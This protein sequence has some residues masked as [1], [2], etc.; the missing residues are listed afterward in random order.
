MTTVEV[1]DSG[2]VSVEI[3]P[4]PVIEVEVVSQPVIEVEVSPGG[5]VQQVVGV[6]PEYA[7][8][9]GVIESDPLVFKEFSYTD[10]DLTQIDVWDSAAKSTLLMQKVLTYSEG[11]L[12][13]LSATYS[14]I[15]LTNTY[16]FVDGDLRSINITSTQG[17]NPSPPSTS[18]TQSSVDMDLSSSRSLVMRLV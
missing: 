6:N 18:P 14:G 5:F 3:T 11:N 9:V 12:A 16:T 1:L 7:I 10:G 4:Q 17:G 2:T 13:T 8:A 15:T